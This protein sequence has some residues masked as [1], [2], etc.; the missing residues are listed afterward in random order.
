MG[1]GVNTIPERKCRH[2][3]QFFQPDPRHH[4]RQR[5]C[6]APECRHAS[7]AASQARWLARP[8]NRDYFRGPDNAQRVQAWRAAHPGYGK[9][10][11]LQQEP[12]QEMMPLQE[13]IKRRDLAVKRAA[14]RASLQE[15]W[16]V[17]SPLVVGLIA[18]LAGTTSQEDAMTM[19]RRFITRGQE[20]LVKCQPITVF[21]PTGTSA[22][23]ADG[24]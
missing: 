23:K 4:A 1:Q 17:Q 5:H 21:P 19:M 12:L 8:E 9:R 3:S 6:T 14:S 16:R 22:E 2:C 18:H 7:K 13:M 15:M 11:K 10:S 20:L 24:F